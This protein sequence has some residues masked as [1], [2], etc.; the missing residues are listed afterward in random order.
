MIAI[1]TIKKTDFKV[2]LFAFYI[3][4]AINCTVTAGGHA[5]VHDPGIDIM[6]MSMTPDLG[7]FAP[8]KM[9][10]RMTPKIFCFLDFLAI[11]QNF[12]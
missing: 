6:R 8:L 10:M 4:F 1:W 2:C 3:L 5:H 7:I 12:L 9:P 11:Y